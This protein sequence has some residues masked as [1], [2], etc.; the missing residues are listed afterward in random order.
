MRAA[1]MIGQYMEDYKKIVN[2]ST[3]PVG[4]GEPPP[5]CYLSYR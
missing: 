3:V 4:T 2:K 1:E 5:G